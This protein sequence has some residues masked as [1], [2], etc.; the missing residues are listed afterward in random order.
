MKTFDAFKGHF[1]VHIQPQLEELEKKRYAMHNKR[2]QFGGLTFLFLFF[3]WILIY[4][5]QINIYGLYFMIIFA[6]Y[7]SYTYFKENYQD[8]T[9]EIEY[10][11]LVVREMMRFMDPSLQYNPEGYIPLDR[12]KESGFHTL[13]P[14]VYTGDDLIEGTIEGTPMMVSEIQAA[15]QLPPKKNKVLDKIKEPELKYKTYFHGFFMI[16]ELQEE[17]KTDVYIFNDDIQH[18]WGHVG[19]LIEETD[20]RYGD[21]V[22]I[23]DINFRKNFKVYAQNRALAEITLKDDFVSKLSEIAKHFKAK[24][25]CILKGNHMY[26]FLDIRKELFKVDTAHSL[27]RS[28]ILKNL[29]KDLSMILS[30]AHTLNDPVPQDESEHSF[31]SIDNNFGG[32]TNEFI[33]DE[34]LDFQP[35][36]AME[37]EEEHEESEYDDFDDELGD[38]TEKSEAELFGMEDQM[39]EEDEISPSQ[40]ME[41]F[42]FDQMMRKHGNQLPLDFD[43]DNNY[44][45]DEKE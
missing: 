34:V 26:V 45:D 23:R 44:E 27:T 24:V 28:F 18:Q 40:H 42:D 32:S 33:Q 2:L 5:D 37:A 9:I 41:Q 20:T 22:P 36:Q 43:N 3:T 19:R 1:K 25:S 39:M 30:V 7:F 6:P 11:E 35:Q 12:W 4:L 21:Y 16:F 13:I 10:K 29:Y 38:H 14:D 15:T 8:D 17:V 31:S